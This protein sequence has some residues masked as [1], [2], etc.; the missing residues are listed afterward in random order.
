MSIRNKYINKYKLKTKSVTHG[1]GKIERFCCFK[2]QTLDVNIKE[3][4]ISNLYLLSS[5]C[6]NEQLCISIMHVSAI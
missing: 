6:E 4:A 3:Y 5:I 2:V 1:K